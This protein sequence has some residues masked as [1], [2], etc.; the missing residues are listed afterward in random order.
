L[1]RADTSGLVV[2][3]FSAA[4]RNASPLWAR[5]WPAGSSSSAMEVA[6]IVF[7]VVM[8]RRECM[9]Q[10]A[11]QPLVHGANLVVFARCVCEFTL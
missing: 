3:A 9:R 2:T 10:D 5:A 1:K 7:L 8:S 4:A 11:L 6:R